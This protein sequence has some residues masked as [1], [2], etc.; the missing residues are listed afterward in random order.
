[1]TV[2]KRNADP[3]TLLPSM[4]RA[5]EVLCHEMRER[6]FDPLLWEAGRSLAREAALDKKGAGS[7]GR[8]MHYYG[9]AADIV[10]ASR[11]WDWPEFY[12]ALCDEAELLGLVSGHRWKRV[13]S[14]HVQAVPV[15]LQNTF[16][17]LPKAHLDG[18]IRPFLRLPKT[19]L[20]YTPAEDL[21]EDVLRTAQPDP[22]KV[23][24]FQRSAKLEVDGDFGPLTREKLRE[25][26]GA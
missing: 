2:P 11:M 17:A 24:E 18:F 15:S 12:D 4:R 3:A 8:S 13:D 23:K 14:V 10:S 1:M 21:L 20:P 19:V 9:A 22:E 6:G 25:K 7:K 26:L 5:I 16:R